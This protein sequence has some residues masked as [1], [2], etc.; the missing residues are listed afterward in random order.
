M[1][2]SKA[3]NFRRTAVGVAK[4]ASNCSRKL[5]APSTLPL[6]TDPHDYAAR[7]INCVRATTR[8]MDNLTSLQLAETGWPPSVTRPTGICSEGHGPHPQRRLVKAGGAR[9]RGTGTAV[10]LGDPKAVLGLYWGCPRAV[11]GLS[12]DSGGFSAAAR[13]VCRLGTGGES[14]LE[15]PERAQHLLAHHRRRR[16]RARQRPLLHARGNRRRKIQTQCFNA[17]CVLVPAREVDSSAPR[18]KPWVCR[19][20]AERRD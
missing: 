13:G 3:A 16:G 6:G 8:G 15:D 9:R 18:V 1:R 12:Q 10:L 19:A 11:P 2:G 17:E 4:A 14:F 5:G 20:D 7:Q